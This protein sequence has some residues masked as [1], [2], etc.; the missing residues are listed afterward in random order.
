VVR[1]WSRLATARGLQEAVAHAQAETLGRG[2]YERRA[3][4]G[5]ERRGE[6]DGT[7][8]PADGGRRLQGPQGR[9]RREPSRSPWWAALG[10]T[11]AVLPTLLVAPY[12][13]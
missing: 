8:P 2:R 4:G 9:G 6:E 13:P 11:S 3:S 12:R 10:R 1:A 5:G 7:V